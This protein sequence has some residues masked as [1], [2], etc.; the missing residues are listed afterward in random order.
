MLNHFNHFTIKLVTCGPTSPTRIACLG[1][2]L[3]LAHVPKLAHLQFD[4]IP[5]LLLTLF[6]D[7]VLTLLEVRSLVLIAHDR[8]SR[9]NHNII[10]FYF[11]GHVVFRVRIVHPLG[12][13]RIESCRRLFEI[14]AFGGDRKFLAHCNLCQE[15]DARA[16]LVGSA[17]VV[18]RLAILCRKIQAFSYAAPGV[19]HDTE[20]T[21]EN[22]RHDSDVGAVPQ[23]FAVL[24]VFMFRKAGACALALDFK[25]LKDLGDLSISGATEEC[26]RGR[27][28]RVAKISVDGFPFH[29]VTLHFFHLAVERVEFLVGWVEHVLFALSLCKQ[30]LPQGDVAQQVHQIGFLLQELLVVDELGVHGRDQVVEL[31]GEHFQLRLKDARVDTRL[32]FFLQKQTDLVQGIIPSLD[33]LHGDGTQGHLLDL[34]PRLLHAPDDRIFIEEQLDKAAGLLRQLRLYFHRPAIL[35][36]DDALLGLLVVLSR[37][38][39]PIVTLRFRLKV[40]A[41]V[42]L[43]VRFLEEP[44]LELLDG[45]VTTRVF[46][47]IHVGARPRARPFSPLRAG[48]SPVAEHMVLLTGLY[49]LHDIKSV[50]TRSELHLSHDGVVHVMPVVVDN[51]LRLEVVVRVSLVDFQDG[52]PVV[53]GWAFLHLEVLLLFLLNGCKLA[54]LHGLELQLFG[55]RQTHAPLVLL[56]ISRVAFL[57]AS[58]ATTRLLLASGLRIHRSRRRRRRRNSLN[59][60]GCFCVMVANGIGSC[61]LGRGGRHAAHSALELQNVQCVRRGIAEVGKCFGDGLGRILLNSLCE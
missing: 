25:D 18:G 34:H 13:N 27:L 2:V 26:V 3:R 9:W 32:S 17:D 55:I 52:R 30:V 61:G 48:S 31:G 1:F 41:P 40:E 46:V 39:A 16:A 53:R 10:A 42:P 14:G 60:C 7:E 35:R 5:E 28:R 19:G 51:D 36:L 37:E 23:E 44:L 24:D 22:C 15:H 12:Y 49:E 43:V 33:A 6:V 56:A 54:R 47:H 11:K 21:G 50:E 45:P 58:L 4:E 20:T 38:F 57:P 29:G 8:F 59:L